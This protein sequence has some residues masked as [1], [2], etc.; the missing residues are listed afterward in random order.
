MTSNPASSNS[1]I[2]ARQNTPAMQRLLKA[3]QWRW[4]RAE[5]W[6][7]GQIFAV[8]TPPMLALLLAP[9]VPAARPWVS[10]LAV[11]L[12]IT[13]TALIDRC[14]KDALKAAAKASELFDT[15]LMH[16]SWNSLAAGKKPSPEETDEAADGWGRL[17]APYPIIDWYSKHV[18]RAPLPLARAI[19][20][21]TNLTYDADLRRIN[22]NLLAIVATALS[23]SVFVLG[24]IS[25]Q[26]FSEWVLAGGVPSAP[27]VT[28]ALRERYRQADA[29]TAND[30]V[31]TEAERLI[32]DIA[33]GR[34]DDEQARTR[35]RAIQDAIYSARARTVLLFPRLYI[36]RR[37]DAERKMD[38]GADHWLQIAGY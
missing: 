7:L 26:G 3:R 18:D 30:G 1:D 34:C 22:K 17:K 5:R 15:T 6:Q 27:F 25:T 32:E 2:A 4:T 20:Q 28:W 21:R 8:L 16:L 38:S 9:F 13:D 36:L 24:L 19:C 35:S 12:T 14:Y 10:L 23:L 11:V 37:K 29:V 31:L 33:N